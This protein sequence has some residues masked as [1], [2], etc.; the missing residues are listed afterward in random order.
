VA[1][2]LVTKG[3]LRGPGFRRLFPDIYL[4]ANVVPTLAMRSRAAHLLV[5]GVV[6]WPAIPPRNCSVLG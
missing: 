4:P 2:G 1:A 5:M 3:Q 6:R